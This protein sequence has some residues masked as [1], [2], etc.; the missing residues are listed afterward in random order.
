MH[1]HI[2]GYNKDC[3]LY[4]CMHTFHVSDTHIFM[5]VA[6][7]YSLRVCIHVRAYGEKKSGPPHNACIHTYTQIYMHLMC[8]VRYR[9]LI[10]SMCS[11]TGALSR[12]EATVRASL[13]VCVCVWCFTRIVFGFERKRMMRTINFSFERK[14]IVCLCMRKS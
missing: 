5:R 8:A 14:R 1:A 10:A 7:I 13:H 3:V 11:K 6:Y 9:M 2:C 4:I 12:A